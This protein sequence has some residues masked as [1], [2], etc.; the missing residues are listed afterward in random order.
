MNITFR[1]PPELEQLLPRPVLAKT[2][3]PDWLRKMPATAHDDILGAELMTVKKCAPFLDAMSYGF[4]M[5]LAC[6]VQITNGRLSWDWDLPATPGETFSRSP[7]ALHPAAQVR[8][9]P[10]ENG[11]AVVL[12][13]NAFWT[14]ELP[15]G[16]SLLCVHP[17]NRTDLPFR[18]LSGL[19]DSD[20]YTQNFINFVAEWTDPGFEGILPKGTPVAQ[21]IP[22]LRES[23][24]YQFETMSQD[25]AQ[26]FHK[27]RDSMDGTAGVYRR[28]MRVRK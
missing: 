2:G 8:G 15:P 1:C 13:F 18:S 26:A 11:V 19:V 25:H 24:E 7:I 4:L 10:F 23:F 22:M 3:L 16:W 6:D 17:L 20:R 12:K 27:T 14:I 21:C 5:P 28:D 9:S